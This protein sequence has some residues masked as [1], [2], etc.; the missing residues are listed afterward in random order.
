MNNIASFACS[1]CLES[2]TRNYGISTIPCGHVFHYN[3]ISKWIRN[4]NQNCAQCRKFC[5]TEKITKLFFSENNDSDH[6]PENDSKNEL[7]E[8]EN[9]KLKKE[10]L[11]TA[12]FYEKESLKLKKKLKETKYNQNSLERNFK[13]QRECLAFKDQKI[14]SLEEQARKGFRP[15]KNLYR[16]NSRSTGNLLTI[17]LEFLWNFFGISLDFSWNFFGNYLE[18]LGNFVGISWQFLGNFLAIL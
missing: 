18:F 14:K 5:S 12:R 2:F 9:L 4:G 6:R 8:N 7:L 10:L 16:N 15:F 1:I 17:S 3:C 13:V 11:V